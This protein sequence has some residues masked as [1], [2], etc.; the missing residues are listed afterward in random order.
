MAGPVALASRG[1]SVLI[2]GFVVV[3]LWSVFTRRISLSGLLQDDKGSF[4]PGRAQ[5]L[6]VTLLT[7]L[8]YL[9]QVMQKPTAFPEIPAFWL[10]ALGSSHGIYLGGKAFTILLGNRSNQS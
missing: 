2:L 3:T 7:A 9:G 4:S 5:M 10:A 8:Q 1:L 6:M